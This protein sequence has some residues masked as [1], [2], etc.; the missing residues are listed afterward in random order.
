MRQLAQLAL[1]E[2]KRRARVTA[3]RL[4]QV[5][6]VRL[7]IQI[8]LYEDGLCKRVADSR[9]ERRSL[10]DKRITPASISTACLSLL[11]AASGCGLRSNAPR[12]ANR[13]SISRKPLWV[14]AGHSVRSADERQEEAATSEDDLASISVNVLTVVQFLAWFFKTTRPR[15]RFGPAR[16]DW[17][18]RRIR[19]E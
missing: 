2:D 1:T 11:T 10:R 7:L 15:I 8:F 17:L 9:H 5:H 13:L 3:T 4:R 6:S 12:P 18:T 19:R 16:F 14:F